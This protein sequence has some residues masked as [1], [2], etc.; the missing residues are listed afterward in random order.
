MKKPKNLSF[1][2]GSGKMKGA[3]LLKLE[4]PVSI[5]AVQIKGVDSQTRDLRTRIKLLPERSG[6]G[7]TL[8]AANTHQDERLRSLCPLR[9]IPR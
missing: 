2:N 9:C 3:I 6:L 8:P 1:S 5:A 4:Q 7:F